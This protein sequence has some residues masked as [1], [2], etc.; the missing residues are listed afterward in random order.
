MLKTLDLHRPPSDCDEEQGLLYDRTHTPLCRICYD[1]NGTLLK[2]CA[3]DGTQG[4]VHRKCLKTWV[5]K[6]S[7]EPS[8]CEICKEPWRI[9]LE[10]PC[11]KFL[12]RWNWIFAMIV[13]Y[14]TIFFGIF[15]FAYIAARPNEIK[16]ALMYTGFQMFL[17]L[18][19]S[20]FGKHIYKLFRYTSSVMLWGCIILLLSEQED[21]QARKELIYQYSRNEEQRDIA[22]KKLREDYELD[23]PW[24][25]PMDN[26]TNR[27]LWIVF[28]LDVILWI[29]Y[30]VWKKYNNETALPTLNNIR[31]MSSSSEDSLTSSE[32]SEES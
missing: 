8:H 20:Y 4:L 7:N 17:M 26:T 29:I 22:L 9:E 16:A 15:N 31:L 24:A 10:S 5:T 28:C 27:Q 13:W 1:S 2:A 18:S 11:E 21:Y 14:F 19:D 23:N 30:Y 6:Y 32:D 3:C 25:W 12:K